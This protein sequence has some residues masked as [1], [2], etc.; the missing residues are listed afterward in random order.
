MYF[1]G[2]FIVFGWF[3]SIKHPGPTPPIDKG[4][5][6]VGSSVMKDLSWNAPN[7]YVRRKEGRDGGREKGRKVARKVGRD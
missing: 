4:V 6:S 1:E 5:P 2:F 7:L 3:G